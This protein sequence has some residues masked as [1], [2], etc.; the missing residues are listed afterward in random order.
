MALLAGHVDVGQEVHLDL[1]LAVAPA[2]LAAPA[3]DVEAEAA[4]L[5]AARARLAR[6]REELADVVEDAGVG[7]RVRAR[8]AADRRLVDVDDLVDL[9]D[10]VDPVVRAGAQPRAVQAVGDRAVE[11]LVDERRLA[12]A[13]DA[14]DAGEDA[15]RELDVDALEVVLARAADDEL[16]ARRA[17]LRPARRSSARPRG[18][19]R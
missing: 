5:V 7:R 18:T 2:D 13:R 9:L 11:D 8:R 10:P 12:R 4:G 16:A 14:G 19:G 15:E 1:D 6:L 3:L 17:A